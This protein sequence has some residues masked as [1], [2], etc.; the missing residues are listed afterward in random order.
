MLANLRN[1]HGRSPTRESRHEAPLYIKIGSWDSE[2]ENKTEQLLDEA[3][4]PRARRIA[5]RVAHVLRE[6]LERASRELPRRH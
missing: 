6:L 2:T 5:M 1:V 4:P 3:L